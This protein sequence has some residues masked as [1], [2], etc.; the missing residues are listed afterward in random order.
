[1]ASKTLKY[2]EVMIMDHLL[3]IYGSFASILQRESLI[4]M[5]TN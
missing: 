1:M 5:G 3:I 2:S 4:H